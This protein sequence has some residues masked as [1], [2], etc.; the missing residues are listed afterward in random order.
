[1]Q[2]WLGMAAGLLIGWIGEW[3]LTR[4]GSDRR[5]A[6][7]DPVLYSELHQARQE[8]ERLKSG[9][10]TPDPLIATETSAA[11]PSRHAVEDESADVADDLTV[12]KGIGPV[13]AERLNAA[14]IVSYADLAQASPQAL[15][16]AV[17]TNQ[18]IAAEDWIAQAKALL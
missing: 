9:A 7:A 2:F 8:L 14:G 6:T 15:K 4:R 16:A 13:F 10:E 18:K 3:L 11:S 12:V 1:M 17:A 5:Q